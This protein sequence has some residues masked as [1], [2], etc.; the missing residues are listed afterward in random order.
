VFRAERLAVRRGC[1]LNMLCKHS[2]QRQLSS[3]GPRSTVG[4][5]LRSSVKRL[6]KMTTTR[7]A[8]RRSVFDV[9]SNIGLIEMPSPHVARSPVQQ[10][11]P[12]ASAKSASTIEPHLIRLPQPPLPFLSS[13]FASSSLSHHQQH[14]P[15]AP[16]MPPPSSASAP[17]SS[18]SSPP[19]F[20]P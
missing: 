12:N 4:C 2:G 5:K 9:N 7:E 6:M 11:N 19:L 1:L 17:A 3:S 8:D 10:T 14:P 15:S 13:S 18:P 16:Q 20:S